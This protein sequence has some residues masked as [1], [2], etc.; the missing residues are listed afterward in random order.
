MLTKLTLGEMTVK[1]VEQYE[2]LKGSTA[3]KQVAFLSS[4]TGTKADKMT[5]ADKKAYGSFLKM[6][7]KFW[8]KL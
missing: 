8:K 4:F 2:S 6:L 1:A 3:E 5:E 7:S